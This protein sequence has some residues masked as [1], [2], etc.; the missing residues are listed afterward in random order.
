MNRSNQSIVDSEVA[1]E[2]QLYEQSVHR[3][4]STEYDTVSP[5]VKAPVAGQCVT[6]SETKTNWDES[7][8]PDWKQSRLWKTDTGRRDYVINRKARLRARDDT[9]RARAILSSLHTSR[10]EDNRVVRKVL[11]VDLRS[12]AVHYAGLDGAVCGF[13]LLYG[14]RVRPEDIDKL[15]IIGNSGEKLLEFV[16]RKYGGYSQ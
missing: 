6:Y 14:E 16:E 13:A 11:S 1:N 15:G 9:G 10:S 3:R 8:W 12:F 2:A 4:H 7:R 5:K